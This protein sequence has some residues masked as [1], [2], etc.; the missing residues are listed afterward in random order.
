V[1]LRRRQPLAEPLALAARQLKQCEAH[2]ALLDR[3]RPLNLAPERQRLCEAALAGQRPPPA[4]VYAAAPDLSQVQRTLDGM[5]EALTVELEAALLVARARELT[6]EARLAS[7]VGLPGFRELAD[8]RFALP[9]AHAQLRPLALAWAE[10]ASGVSGPAPALH[11]S[12]DKNDPESLWSLLSRRLEAKRL[13]VR[14]EVTPGLASLAAVA[15]GVVRV[16]G[17]ARLSREVAQR[18]ALHEVEGHVVPRMA[19]RALAG[20]FAAGSAGAGEDEEGRALLLEERAAL[21][22]VERKAELGFRYLAA[23]SVRQGAEFWETFQLLLE[24]G[25]GSEL[26]VDLC[27]RVQ[28][29][30][31]LGRELV[32]LSGYVRVARSLESRP[33]LEGVLASGRVSVTAA[34]SLLDAGLVELDDDRDVV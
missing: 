32:Y 33:E 22:G 28:R 9:A 25:A 19:G 4:F 29:G 15:D 21:M 2:V 12:D 17:G 18:I 24:H 34:A 5:V 31:G 23:E 16:R 26:A 3:A 11:F 20:V 10:Q 13:S 30:G 14:L 7:R 27:C 6:L 1:R 8:Q